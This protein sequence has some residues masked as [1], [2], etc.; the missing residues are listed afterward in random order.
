MGD[1]K[2]IMNRSVRGRSIE[3]PEK[4]G[5]RGCD[6]RLY[7]DVLKRVQKPQ[8]KRK[9]IYKL[10][11]IKSKKTKTK[12]FALRNTVKNITNEARDWENIS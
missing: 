7:K 5:V 12:A 2:T 11:C 1:S 6:H 8:N 4:N 9:K 3:F 10:D